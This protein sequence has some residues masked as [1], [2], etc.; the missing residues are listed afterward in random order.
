M[1]ID[2]SIIIPSRSPQYLQQTIDDL[3]IHSETNIEII[4]VFDGIW[5]PL[6]EDPRVKIIHHGTVHKNIGMRESINRGISLSQGK[7]IA[8]IDE[9]C[10]VS[11]GYDK[12]LIADCAD[13]EVIILRRGRLDAEKWEKINDGR[14]DI[15]YMYTE[16]P[17]L[18][19]F[20]STQGLHGNIW[21]RPG[22]E[23]LLIDETPT[24]QG[25]FYFMSRKH[26]DT[27]IKELSTESYGPFTGEAQEISMATWLSG[28]RVLVNKNAT[29]LHWHKGRNGKGYSFSS[30]QY[31]AFMEAKERGR[32]FAV[33][34]W[35]TTKDYKYDFEWFINHFPDMP[36]WE[37]DWKKRLED[38]KLKDFRYSPEFTTWKAH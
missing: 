21:E 37:G 19:P 4:V 18:K 1:S 22:R 36:G 33:D 2:L 35:T 14:A 26:W 28:G 10:A 3:L 30:K 13:N 5:S 25:S 17:F 12:I 9:H 20:D 38:G 32:Q 7:Y 31:E 34:F 23:H 29:Y 8:K 27:T 11:Q 16:F 15:D 6:K 24:M